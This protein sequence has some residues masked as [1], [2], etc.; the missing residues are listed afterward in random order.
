MSQTG[1]NAHLRPGLWAIAAVVCLG[2]VGDLALLGHYESPPQL[3]PFALCAV[4]LVASLVGAFKPSKNGLRFVWLSAGIIVLGAAFGLWEHFEHNYVF[5]SEIRPNA[6][7]RELLTHAIVGASPILAPGA[8]MVLSTLL[9]LAAWR[10][11]QQA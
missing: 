9:A 6:G 10:H 2:T 4:G 5:E 11:P 1:P 7:V 3:V 8:L